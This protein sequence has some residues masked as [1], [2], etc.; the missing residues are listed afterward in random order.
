VFASARIKLKAWFEKHNRPEALLKAR[1]QP[2]LR[3]LAEEA[4]KEWRQAMAYFEHVKDRE[5]VDY[6]IKNLEAA[7]KRYNYLLRQL[8]EH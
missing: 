1:P 7:E 6:A 4:K 2:T 5:L 3:E 8:R